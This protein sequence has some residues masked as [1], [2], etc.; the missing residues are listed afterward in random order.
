MAGNATTTKAGKDMTTIY[1]TRY[2][3]TNGTIVRLEADMEADGKSARAKR[4]FC[5]RFYEGDF[6]LT[7]EGA[8]QLFAQMVAKKKESLLKQTL[9]LEKM[10]PK[11]V[12]QEVN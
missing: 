8:K 5:S 3:L 7:E 9:K 2:S 6:S 12:D 10:V 11:I 1:L 4:F